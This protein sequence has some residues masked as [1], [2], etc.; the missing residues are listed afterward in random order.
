MAAERDSGPRIWLCRSVFLANSAIP[1]IQDVEICHIVDFAPYGE[2]T[3]SESSGGMM[4][5]N[6]MSEQGPVSRTRTAF[7]AIWPGGLVVWLA[8]W[9]AVLAMPAAADPA[10]TDTWTG[11]GGDEFWSTAGNWSTGVPSASDVACI[12]SGVA[13]KVATGANHVGVL[14]DTGKLVVSGGS[15]EV[16]SH[17]AT[18]HVTSLTLQEGAE[19]EGAGE[20]NVTGTLSWS[21]GTMSGSGS[22]VLAS[23]AT[24]SIAVDRPNGWVM[25]DERELAVEGTLTFASGSVTMADGAHVQNLH[26]GS[27]FRVVG[28]RREQNWTRTT[29]RNRIMTV[30]STWG[31]PENLASHVDKHEFS[32]WG[33]RFGP[34]VGSDHLLGHVSPLGELYGTS[35]LAPLRQLDPELEFS[36]PVCPPRPVGNS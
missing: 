21:G 14:L 7:L 22:T 27:A 23:G 10:C 16:A 5:G 20:L 26:Q 17:L 11:A 29:E 13:V 4:S 31:T 9:L 3:A 33:G 28:I 35:P 32:C 18:S 34:Q 8:L 6:A 30:G 1:A 19:L 2:N 24:G 12:G 15:L 36:Q 25:L